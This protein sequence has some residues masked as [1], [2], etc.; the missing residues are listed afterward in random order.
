MA[1][2]YS[3]GLTSQPGRPLRGGCRDSAR[4]ADDMQGP[5]EAVSCLRPLVWILFRGAPSL[6]P[7]DVC[8]LIARSDRGCGVPGS[9]RSPRWT[10]PFLPMPHRAPTY[11]K[12]TPP[13]AFTPHSRKSRGPDPSP[14]LSGGI[15]S[16]HRLASALS[17]REG[18]RPLFRRPT[19]GS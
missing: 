12:T 2:G 11:P 16:L 13:P 4:C 10:V 8:D 3:T 18:R 14:G 1:A 9:P 5:R 7:C 19:D 15:S 6:P 17:G